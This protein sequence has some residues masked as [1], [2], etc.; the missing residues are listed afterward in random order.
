MDSLLHRIGYKLARYLS[1]TDK[2]VEH[3]T[4]CSREALKAAI[5]P[6][7]ILL[8]DGNSKIS[9]AIKY[10]T[11]STWSHAALFIGRASDIMETDNTESLL[12]E[13]DVKEGV[14]TVSLDHY[15]HK[16][17]RICRPVGL[18][19]AEIDQV[20]NFMVDKVGYTYDLKN[21]FD[22]ARYLIQTP[23]VGPKH[24]RRLLALG[25]GDPTK[26]I[27]TSLIAQAFQ[28]VNYPILPSIEIDESSSKA[29]VEYHKEILHIRHHSLFAPRDFD[30]SPY[31][32]I[33]KPTIE[34]GFDPH[35]L[36]WAEQR[37]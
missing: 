22:L 10:I 37:E 35:S 19:S 8:I 23:P 34:A 4:T 33:I 11:Q 16:H 18:S 2:D 20:I 1:E 13:A 30:V 3:V 17:V 26:A 31:F 12:I 6:G 27:C 5:R 29:V 24:R 14:R 21:I 7:D 9:M 32:Q 28:L 25:S 15:C 36:S